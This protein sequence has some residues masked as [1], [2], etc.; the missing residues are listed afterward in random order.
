MVN[1]PARGLGAVSVEKIIAF[2]GQKGIDLLEALSLSTEENLISAK[3][4]S[5]AKAFATVFSAA[6][7]LL[8]QDNGAALEHLIRESSLASYYEQ[9]D[10][11]YATGKLDNLGTLVTAVGEYP[12]GIEGMVAF[13]ES[14]SLDPTTIGHKDP[15]S[16]PGVSLIT[17]HNTKGLEFERVFVT[18]MEEGL[19]PSRIS[20]SEADIEEER[21]LFYV[22]I[23][24]AKR[25]L[26]LTSSARRAMWGDIKFQS[27]SRFLLEIPPGMVEIEGK[28]EPR[29]P[30]GYGNIIR[31]GATVV[32]LPVKRF[33]QG[34][35]KQGF[36]LGDRVYH[37][38]YG[39]GE[40]QSAKTLRGKGMIEV[41]FANGQKIS[42]F[43]ENAVLEKVAID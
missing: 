17:M 31:R 21:R 33:E 19:F 2:A 11:M 40:V 18:G 8:K 36:S 15:S 23:T 35:K 16:E 38:E 34:A 42:F 24:R 7:E 12:A 27:P 10:L 20:E 13:L 30:M 37:S 41:Q 32:P 29:R 22:A 3:A 4:A 5:A 43:A 26:V 9:Q 28:D 39:E 1:K 25:H 6:K 14:L